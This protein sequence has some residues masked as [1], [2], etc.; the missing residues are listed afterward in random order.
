MEKLYSDNYSDIN[1]FGYLM[2][3]FQKPRINNASLVD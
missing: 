3:A 1:E 2:S